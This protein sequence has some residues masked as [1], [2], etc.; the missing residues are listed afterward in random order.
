VSDRSTAL[1]KGIGARLAGD[2]V[3]YGLGGVAN[4]AVAILLVPVYAR[5][6]GPSGVGVTGV[7]NSTITLA[8]MVASLAL[9]Q[10][11]FRWYLREATGDR[12]RSTVLATTLAIRIAA[13]LLAL[14]LVLLAAIP[15]TDSLYDGGY[16]IVFVLAAPIVMFDSFNQ[17]PL[18]FLR[19]ERR[20]RDYI[21]IT[22]TRAILGSVLIVVLVVLLRTGVV[23]VAIGSAVAA[24]VS[25]MMGGWALLRVGVRPR[26]DRGLARV[27]LAFALPLVPASIAGWVLNL[28]D[29][30]MLQLLTG[31]TSEVGVYSLGYTV[32]L[33]TNALVVQPF[34]LAWGAAY[35]E[36]SRQENA[37]R[38][39]ARVLTWFVALAAGT[40]L[41]LSAVG[42]D[43][44]RILVGDEFEMSRYI[45]PFS[46]F[47]YVLYGSYSIVAAGLGIV[48]RSGLVAITM[49][50][51]AAAAVALNLV[52]IPR[53]G[54]FGAAISTLAS[55][56]LL[57]VLTGWVSH[58]RYPV[59][60]QLGRV[61]AMLLIAG[62][63]SAA[64][65]AGPDH[66]AWRLACIVV[67][68]PALLALRLVDPN[69]AKPVLAIV[70]RR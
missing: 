37:S 2:T 33:I 52:L 62:G 29:R 25:G 35:W 59:P 26:I 21:R 20:P 56:S 17:V 63:L 49:G 12:D 39:F 1:T 31:S 55:Y 9:P 14:A 40:A 42:T 11:F 70:R 3:V 65:L 38:A 48:G 68:A 15:I 36:I 16:L 23:G 66:V 46:A 27:M 5:Q 50:V 34:A 28:S 69:D 7:L 54:I 41:M 45:V 58:R 53:F 8:L 32:G 61:G 51:A 64:A 18:S 4:Q 22:L 13:S 10:A 57:A 44:I 47:A 24:M 30:P 43:A 60:W 67:Y 6:L 19:A